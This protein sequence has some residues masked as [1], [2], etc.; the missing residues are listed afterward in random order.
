[1]EILKS[2]EQLVDEPIEADA[3]AQESK[4]AMSRRGFLKGAVTGAVIAGGVG[5]LGGVST[6]M[7]GAK[8]KSGCEDEA[9]EAR[10]IPPVGPPAKWDAEA[11]VLVVGT[12]GGGLTAAV[13]ALDGG[14]SVIV[15][16]KV[17]EQSVGG[18]TKQAIVYITYGGSR[19]Q[20]A[21]KFAY[22]GYPFDVDKVVQEVARD[23]QYTADL[24]LLRELF[25]KDG[26]CV[27]YLGDL[28][29]P[30]ELDPYTAPMCHIWKDIDKDGL[31]SV[32]IKP[33]TDLVYRVA[34]EKGAKFKFESTVIGLVSDRGRIVGVK[35]RE[36]QTGKVSFIKGKKAVILASGGFASNRPMQ[37]KYLPHV[38]KGAACS[39]A[40]PS[41]TGEIIRMGFG[42]G[43]D[44]AGLG[45]STSFD[46]GIDW[47]FGNKGTFHQH[48][49]NG[50]TQLSRQPWFGVD[51][52]GKRY[53]YMDCYPNKYRAE[54]ELMTNQGAVTMSLPDGRGYLI[55]DK[56][57][58]KN[59]KRLHKA[60]FG[61]RRP[62]TTDMADIDRVPEW[63]HPK[64]WREGVEYAIKKGAIRK[65]N[66]IEDL[67]KQL[68]F[69]SGVLPE[70][71][72]KW[73]EICES[74][75]DP[76]FY[77]PQE[78]L[79]PVLEGPFYG[80]RIGAILFA[81][82]CGLKVNEKMQVMSKETH[83]PIP[84]LYACFH[85]A[86]GFLGENAISG[87]QNSSCVA[88]SFTSGY[89]AGEQVAKL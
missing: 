44:I 88:A 3:S 9:E 45:S 73:N 48:L 19:Y 52:T 85:T 61:C 60:S 87:A 81:T 6:A 75:K 68:G 83:E 23:Y 63:L 65:S 26:E 32:A 31:I 79:I 47:M 70:S 21:K 1:M 40:M 42:A 43:A 20:N 57:F 72:R 22:G 34:K 49:Y 50:S 39:Y 82:K 80:I 54:W 30:W 76:E 29:V 46:G 64:D 86:G 74:G 59:I 69:E 17:A 38:Y 10:D 5:L 12:G 8:P 13:K 2:N 77:F 28:G 55:M 25:V 51:I 35:I 33:V 53:P 15:V 41:D 27:D 84:G 18:T 36:L 4:T 56:N 58:E 66:T 89:I 62:L 14:K 71:V 78:W 67:G 7:A 37:K 11:D 24:K 16:E